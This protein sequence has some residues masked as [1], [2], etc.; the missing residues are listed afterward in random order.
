MRGGVT[1]DEMYACGPEDREI[2]AKLVKAN[3]EVAKKTSM[4]F[5]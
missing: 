2:F 5:F 3:L 1:L 4:P